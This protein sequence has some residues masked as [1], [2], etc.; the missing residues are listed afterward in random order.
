[1]YRK[2]RR[3]ENLRSLYKN[4]RALE[5]ILSVYQDERR[6]GAGERATVDAMS[7]VI[8]TQVSRHDY[9]SLHLR[10]QAVDVRSR[11]MLSSQKE[12]FK[13]ACREVLGHEPL[14]EADRYHLQF[15]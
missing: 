9:I 15:R 6:S 1:M 7:R 2:L 4:H 10:G 5:E 12:V 14:K 3:G 11:T 8:Q 13:K